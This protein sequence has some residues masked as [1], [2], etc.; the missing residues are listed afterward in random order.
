MSNVGKMLPVG[1]ETAWLKLGW[2]WETSKFKA[3]R[4]VPKAPANFL[5]L[6]KFSSLNICCDACW[7]C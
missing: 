5:D 6:H 7:S 4:N 1:I 2:F 3:K